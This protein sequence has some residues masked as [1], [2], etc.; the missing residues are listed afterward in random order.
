MY[1]KLASAAATTG[2]GDEVLKTNVGAQLR[3]ASTMSGC[4]DIA[5]RRTVRLA[6]TALNNGDFIQQAQ[7][8][9]VTQPRSP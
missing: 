9:G 1:L 7:L 3:T 5:A 4:G 8:F 2:A 6:E